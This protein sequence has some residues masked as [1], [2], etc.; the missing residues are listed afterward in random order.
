MT[1]GIAALGRE[2]EKLEQKELDR[3]ASIYSNPYIK[4]D[5]RLEKN[6]AEEIILLIPHFQEKPLPMYRVDLLLYLSVGV[7]ILHVTQGT[8]KSRATS[9]RRRSANCSPSRTLNYFCLVSHAWT[10]PALQFH[11]LKVI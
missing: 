6:S 2:V 11:F 5:R 9:Q 1:T 3:V 4:A 7:G 8:G 10:L